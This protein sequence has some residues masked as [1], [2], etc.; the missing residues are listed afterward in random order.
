MDRRG[1]ESTFQTM[2][3]RRDLTLLFL[4]C[5]LLLLLPASCQEEQQAPP[6]VGGWELNW[7][8][9][10]PWPFSNG[11]NGDNS[12]APS[13]TPEECDSLLRYVSSHDAGMGGGGR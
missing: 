7:D 13:H 8:E 12:D 6:D 5:C 10:R 3:R 2:A 11:K 4:G 1:S 9:E